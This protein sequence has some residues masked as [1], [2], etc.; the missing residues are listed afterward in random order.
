MR[1]V[2]FVLLALGAAGCGYVGDPLPPA[3]SIPVRITDL[4]AVERGNRIVVSFTIPSLTTEG[5][6]IKRL[7]PVELQI[8]NKT[9]QL[10]DRK[11][12]NVTTE[13]PAA[14]FTGQSAAVK[15]RVENGRGRF[16]DWSNEVVL[17]IVE[18]LQPP[19]EVKAE[20][21]PKG[22]RVTWRDPDLHPG[23]TWRIFR[24]DREKAVIAATP[25]Y[26]DT[27]AEYG[28]D[29]K[30]QVQAVL[31]TAESER[32]QIAAITPRDVFPPAIPAGLNAVLGLNSVELS[33][34][35]N[36]EPDLKAY[37]VYRSLSDGPF[38]AIADNLSSPAY[39]DKQIEGNKKY[40]YAV[41]AID[42]T[43]N[44]SG[45]SQA[46]EVQTP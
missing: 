44:E 39:S 42:Q 10:Q 30:Y 8:G 17:N 28:K 7:G 22:A 43:G 21:D 45:K 27:E 32:S 23:K 25:E 20:S 19:A 29:Y 6:G 36:T 16:S 11:P 37:R 34:D 15:V 13:V 14:E 9:I 38:Q 2:A 40:K 41:T 24:L 1:T 46:A 33:W 12:G 5:L 35:P 26:V 18:P 4:T 31:N 3:L